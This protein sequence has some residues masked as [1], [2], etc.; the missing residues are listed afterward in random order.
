MSV[1]SIKKSILRMMGICII[2]NMAVGCAAAPDKISKEGEIPER[3][4]YLQ[5]EKVHQLGEMGTLSNPTL[6]NLK[7]IGAEFTISTA[8]LYENPEAAG[9]D[10]N[11][12]LA[13]LENCYDLSAD[14]L[15]ASYTPDFSKTYFLLCDAS[16]K[17]I[18]FEY[19]NITAL[20]LVYLP[21]ANEELKI[22]GLPAFFS[23]PEEVEDKMDYYNFNLPVNTSIDIKV[24]WWVDMEQCEK[25]NLYLMSNYGGDKEFQQY[26]E[27][28]L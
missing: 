4:Q 23:K 27:L 1:F 2:C 22:T 9:I 11:Q 20:S 18:S 6:Q 8:V 15:D 21:D 16:I 13:G 17:N 14:I 12:V 3:P 7:Q 5:A 10:V 25:E 19:M 26:W 28:G 24:G